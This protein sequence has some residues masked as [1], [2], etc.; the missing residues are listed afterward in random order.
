VSSTSA[1]F[2]Q[3]VF[4]LWTLLFEY[5]LHFVMICLL[6]MCWCFGSQ[7]GGCQYY[8]WEDEM[9]QS[10][11]QPLPLSPAPLQAVPAAPLQ[12]VLA[13]ATIP[14]ST[15][16]ANIQEVCHA[17]GAMEGN[18]V[19][20]SNRVVDDGIIQQLRWLEKLVFVCIF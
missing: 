4:L 14:T 3:F 8:Q 12:A 20:E 19:G 7:V 13:D 10:S 2:V 15:P 17:S 16:L 11:V 6:I 5:G 18:R 1:F 9:G